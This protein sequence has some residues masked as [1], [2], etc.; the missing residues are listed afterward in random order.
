MEAHEIVEILGSEDLKKSYEFE[1]YV[2]KIKGILVAIFTVFLV[3]P[4][5][6]STNPKLSFYGFLGDLV[7]F[8]VFIIAG[9]MTLLLFVMIIKK[10]M[11]VKNLK[12]RMTVP[13][14]RAKEYVYVFIALIVVEI[15]LLWNTYILSESLEYIFTYQ[16]PPILFFNTAVL[17]LYF[18]LSK[19]DAIIFCKI[20][21]NM[22]E[23]DNILIYN[24][25]FK[26]LKYPNWINPY[27]IYEKD[28]IRIEVYSSKASPSKPICVLKI[29]GIKNENI[30]IVRKIMCN[31]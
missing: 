25:R 22:D 5:I 31:I 2:S 11:E 24:F 3:I 19:M 14:I 23:I 17:M 9:I 7:Y 18:I 4:I 6:I 15:T 10:V 29:S 27:K 26:V 13:K 1:K 28:G 12:W 30:E 21:K 20:N 16:L 8:W